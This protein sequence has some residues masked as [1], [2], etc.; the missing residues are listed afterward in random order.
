MLGD[1]PGG[2]TV[3]MA[4]LGVLALLG[5]VVALMLPPPLSAGREEQRAGLV[6]TP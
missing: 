1:A 2:F 6:P 4:G 5:V 3:P